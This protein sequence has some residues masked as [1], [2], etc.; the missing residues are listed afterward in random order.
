MTVFWT[1]PR[2]CRD[3]QN[4]IPIPASIL[5]SHFR[6]QSRWDVTAEDRPSAISRYVL[7]DYHDYYN[8]YKVFVNLYNTLLL[9]W[10]YD[11][12]LEANLNAMLFLAPCLDFKFAELYTISTLLSE[13]HG[14][15]R[16]SLHTAW[17]ALRADIESTAAS[18]YS[19]DRL[20]DPTGDPQP[21]DMFAIDHDHAMEC[22]RRMESLIRDEQ[23]LEVGRLSLE[24]SKKAIQQAELGIKEGKRMKMRECYPNHP[25]ILLRIQPST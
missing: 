21:R 19:W 16:E 9:N 18:R 17:R 7:S 25:W 12:V 5:R 10:P 6:V 22:A 4:D 24:E 1:P 2:R 15:N 23:Q 11:R 3:V 20:W 14:T 8:D 13:S